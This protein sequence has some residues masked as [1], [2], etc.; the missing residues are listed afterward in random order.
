MF[1]IIVPTVAW[2]QMKTNDQKKQHKARIH[3]AAAASTVHRKGKG[4]HSISPMVTVIYASWW[5][6][7]IIFPSICLLISNNI[8]IDV[9]YIC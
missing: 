6:V 5:A 3:C 2:A 8:D 4:P 9:G 7:N 1:I